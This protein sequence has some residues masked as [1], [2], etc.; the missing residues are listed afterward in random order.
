MNPEDARS[1]CCRLRLD[2]KTLEKRG[3]G[4][5][6]ANPLTGSI[7][8]VTI[9]MA[10]LGY[11][12]KNEEE[13]TTGLEKLML[14]A[15]DSLEIKR[16]ILESFTEKN[17][18][19]YARFYLRSVKEHLG[20]YWKNHFSTIGLLGMN[21]ACVNLFQEDI[22]SEKGRVFTLGILDFMRDKLI[23]FQTET[24]NNYNLEATPAEGTSY[25]LAKQDKEKF[26]EILCANDNGEPFYTNSTQLP[27][28]LTEDVFEVLDLQD[29]IQTK[30]TG[31]TVIHLFIGEHIEDGNVVKNMVRKICEN[32]HLPYFTFTPTFSVCPNHGYLPGELARCPRC[33]TECEIYS[34]IVGYL[35]P[36]SQWNRGKKEEFRLRKTFKV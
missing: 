18:Y 24:G 16:K 23:K 31:G 7:G 25:R 3:G 14:L 36:V 8:V 30:Y 35:R 34:R 4:L 6:G 15:R 11:L 26:P 1:M 28:N 20:E 17:L 32:Y 19:P 21:E 33:N 27:V 10:R 2:T 22:A 9:N 5:F 13:F 12:S 29:E